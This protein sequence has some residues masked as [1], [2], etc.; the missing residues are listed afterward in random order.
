MTNEELREDD[1]R[2]MS[3][4]YRLKES[5]RKN[6]YWEVAVLSKSGLGA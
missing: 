6:E 4:S 3:K 5:P 2:N 1:T